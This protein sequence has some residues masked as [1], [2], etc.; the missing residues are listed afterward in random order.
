MAGGP[1][2]TGGGHRLHKTKTLLGAFHAAEPAWLVLAVWLG[3]G[4]GV[5]IA[6]CELVVGLP[7][8]LL[9]S[10]LTVSLPHSTVILLGVS[11]ALRPAD[12]P[13]YP[14]R[15]LPALEQSAVGQGLFR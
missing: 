10:T 4:G 3:G 14:C 2:F 11:E 12:V 8:G 5:R 7:L 13:H 15:F 1:F 9:L 6:G